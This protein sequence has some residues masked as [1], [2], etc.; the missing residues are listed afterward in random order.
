MQ[1]PFII[2]CIFIKVR[3]FRG[4]KSKNIYVQNLNYYNKTK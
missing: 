1:I 2:N 4:K 3:Y